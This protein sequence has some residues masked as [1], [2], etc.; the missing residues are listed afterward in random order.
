MQRHSPAMQSMLTRAYKIYRRKK[1]KIGKAEFDIGA[2][3]EVLNKN[4]GHNGFKSDEQGLVTLKA[5]NGESLIAILG[6]GSGKSTAFLLPAYLRRK[7]GFTL[8]VSPL[9]ALMNQFA[10]KYSWVEAIHGDVSETWK[11]WRK[12][13]RRQVHL[14]QVAPE[15]LRNDLFRTT[16]VKSVKASKRKLDCFVLDEVHCVSDWGHEFRPEY[17]WAAEYLSDLEKKAK[18]SGLQRVLLTATANDY[19]EAEVLA[20][21]GFA[22]KNNMSPENIIRG[23]VARPEIYLSCRRCKKPEDKFKYAKKFLI[24]QANRPLPRGVKRRI[25]LYTQQAV[26]N[27]RDSKK[28]SELKK[29]AN[30]NANQIAKVLRECSTKRCSISA[31]T[32]SSK[33]MKAEEREKA[34]KYFKNAKSSVGQVRIM[35]ATNAFGLG[36]D[37]KCIPGVIHFYPRPSLSEYWQQVGRAGRGFSLADGEWTESLSTFCN[38]DIKQTYYKAS[39]SAL[40][41]IYNSFTIPALHSLIAWD[42]PPGSSKVALKTE[43]GNDTVF[44]KMVQYFQKENL[45]GKSKISNSFPKKYGAAYIY[46]VNIKRLRELDDSLYG[47]LKQKKLLN[48]HTKKYVRYLRI[49]SQ[50][51]KKRFI[52]LDQSDFK[53][54]RRQ[55]VLSRLTRWAEAGALIREPHL[56]HP[57]IITFR[58]KKKK[59][60]KGLIKMI[61][62]SWDKWAS[63]KEADFYLQERVLKARGHGKRCLLIH[64]AFQSDEPACSS[65]KY[66]RKRPADHVPTWLK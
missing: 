30:L 25:L 7:T 58:V 41:G 2:I 42:R 48:R 22:G 37:Y 63:A 60:T 49:A 66:S 3:E 50:S 5:V 64:E 65:S 61:K 6:T 56:G 43:K 32:F 14:L 15:T 38:G 34:I 52:R 11:V 24:R 31:S 47:M 10:D 18:V 20:L 12:I 54:D 39:A 19:V 17:W 40:D 46:P 16:L 45:L 28:I 26:R 21:F 59:L 36:M 9:K 35:V 27:G 4:I 62:V 51:T 44:G 13:E 23:P 57:G 55:T 33:G 8:V 1:Y 29:E 53:L